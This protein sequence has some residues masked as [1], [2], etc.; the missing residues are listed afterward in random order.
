MA[1]VLRDETERILVISTTNRATDA[2]AIATGNA[3]KTVARED[4]HTGKILRIGKGGAL[5]T[6]EATQLTDMLRGTETEFLARIDELFAQLARA[7][8]FEEKALLR[9]QAKELRL[10]MRDTALRNFLDQDVRVVISTAFKATAFLNYQGIKED[11]GDGFA[12]FTTVF[13][14]EAGL[15][16]RAAIAALSLLASRRV[17]LVGDSKQLAPISRLCRILPPAQGNWLASSGLSHLD[18]IT[19]SRV[20]VHVL[21]EQRRMH[22]AVCSVISTYQYDGFLETAP[23]VVQRQYKLPHLLAN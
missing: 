23:E 6:F 2:A 22:P 13:I 9:K 5:K 12:P 10:E 7:Q 19:A 18:D 1:R 16:S 15:V 11:L 3:A 21:R 8:A 4:L 20:G 17:I 14:D